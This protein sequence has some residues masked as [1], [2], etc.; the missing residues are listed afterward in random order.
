MPT[1]ASSPDLDRDAA[2]ARRM[3]RG[4]PDFIRFYSI[5]LEAPPVAFPF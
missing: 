2:P 3:T 1:Q 4:L 5:S